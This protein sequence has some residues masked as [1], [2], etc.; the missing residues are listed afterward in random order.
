MSTRIAVPSDDGETISRH[1]GQARY[2]QVLTLE[3]GQVAS[4]ELRPKAS[5]QHGDA[6]HAA[7]IHPGQQMVATISDCQVL[8]SGGM[9]APAFAKASA[10]GLEV[11][12]TRE[13]TIQAAVDAYLAGTLENV[14]TLIHAPH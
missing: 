3:A 7:G 8:I 10:A 11:I 9:G 4:S 13:R 14:P 1:F 12:M 2:F 6:S 5:H